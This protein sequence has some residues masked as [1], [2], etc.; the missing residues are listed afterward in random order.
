M[1]DMQL[2]LESHT[3]KLRQTPKIFCSFHFSKICLFYNLCCQLTINT[4]QLQKIIDPIKIP[5]MQ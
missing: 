1:L 2:R 4:K 5:I 3:V